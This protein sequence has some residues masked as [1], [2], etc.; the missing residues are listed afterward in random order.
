VH[1]LREIQ[2][3]EEKIMRVFN[4]VFAFSLGITFALALT[5][6]DKAGRLSGSV[7][8]VDKSGSQITIQQ[9]TA[10]RV[11]VFTAATKFTAG[12]SGNSKTADPATVDK[13][14]QGNYLTCEGTWSGVKLAASACTVR[15]SKRP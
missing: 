1:Q 7:L 5:A 3:K 13:V 11:V 12:S 15:P 4:R 9:G 2:T 8:D 6:A 10:H 14:K